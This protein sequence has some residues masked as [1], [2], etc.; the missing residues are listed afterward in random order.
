VE[1]SQKQQ[2]YMLIGTFE[3]LAAKQHQYDGYESYIGAL[4]EYWTAY[5]ELCRAAGGRFP[6]ARTIDDM[7]Q[8]GALPEYES[9][10]AERP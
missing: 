5:V 10:S 8:S 6:G 1:E 9:T 3:L 4:R 7:Q 2:N